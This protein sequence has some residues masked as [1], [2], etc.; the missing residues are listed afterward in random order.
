MNSALNKDRLYGVHQRIHSADL[1]LCTK[2]ALFSDLAFAAISG[3]L[4][5]LMEVEKVLNEKMDLTKRSKL[6]KRSLEQAQ[7]YA[8]TLGWRE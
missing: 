2:T 1:P 5:R 6:A 3:S 8:R 7:H 4:D